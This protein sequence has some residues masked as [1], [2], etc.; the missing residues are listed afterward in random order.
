M[1]NKSLQY[2]LISCLILIVSQSSAARYH[3]K[4]SI[5]LKDQSLSDEE[6]NIKVGDWTCTIGQPKPDKF[7]SE[8]RRLG[9]GVADGLQAYL[10]PVCY[11]DKKTGKVK[12][13]SGVLS[14]QQKKTGSIQVALFCE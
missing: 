12:S 4:F 9:C 14:L 7:D 11:K 8:A 2:A 1:K 13:E 3:W 6:S 5:D 10:L